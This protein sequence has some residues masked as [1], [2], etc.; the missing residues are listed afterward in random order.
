[1]ELGREFRYKSLV[2][3]VRDR[4]G[5][6][7]EPGLR[8]RLGILGMPAVGVASHWHALL[9]AARPRTTAGRCNQLFWTL[10]RQH[11]DELLRQWF[12]EDTPHYPPTSNSRRPGPRG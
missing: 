7:T 6:S 11:H 10:Q 2:V 8:V 4:A 3:G 1:M 9:S 12:A 5:E